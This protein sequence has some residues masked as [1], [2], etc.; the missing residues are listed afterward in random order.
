[1]NSRRK[2][3]KNSC[4]GA[5]GMTILPSFTIKNERLT[6]LTILHTNDTHSRIHPFK[7]G[8]YKG[9][10]GMAERAT[11]INGIRKKCLQEVLSY[12]K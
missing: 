8:K 4:I 5:L 9:Y 10:G 6:K 1:M 2:F 11:I 3:I 7:T 12:S